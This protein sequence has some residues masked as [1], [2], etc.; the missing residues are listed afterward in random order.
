MVNGSYNFGSTSANPLDTGNGYA[1][2]LLG[3]FQQYQ[4][5]DYRVDR[6]DTHWL[7]E[8]TRRTRGA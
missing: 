1:N 6:E 4:E 5:L 3:I 2:A 8:A 7:G